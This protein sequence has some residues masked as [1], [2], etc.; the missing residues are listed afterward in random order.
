M[1]I[2]YDIIR[3][4]VKGNF[5]QSLNEIIEDIDNKPYRNKLLEQ[6]KISGEEFK[7]A[8]FIPVK[9][10][11]QNIIIMALNGQTRQF[12]KEDLWEI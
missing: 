10:Y 1:S 6:G 11:N 4:K 12:L 2:L 9:T 7:K 5:P 8:K 3:N